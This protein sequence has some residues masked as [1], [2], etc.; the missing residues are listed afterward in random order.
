MENVL[1]FTQFIGSDDSC[2]FNHQTPFK[3]ELLDQLQHW[4]TVYMKK[5]KTYILNVIIWLVLNYFQG[6]DN[7]TYCKCV[8]H[9]LIKSY[10]CQT[11]IETRSLKELL[12]AAEHYEAFVTFYQPWNV[13]KYIYLRTNFNEYPHFIL[14]Y[15]FTR[16]LCFLL[17]DI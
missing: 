1:P 12:K 7:D 5:K 17:H 15:T 6:I 8:S 2:V 13:T 14:L 9:S 11:Q 16:I 3:V 10:W 4:I